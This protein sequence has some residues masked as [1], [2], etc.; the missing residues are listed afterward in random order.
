MRR[1]IFSFHDNSNFN[2]SL[3]HC[4]PVA[5]IRQRISRAQRVGVS[6]EGN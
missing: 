5:L 2:P 1:F 4:L 3:G 6:D